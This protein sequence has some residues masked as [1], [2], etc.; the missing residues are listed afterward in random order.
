M[1][2]KTTCQCGF[3][4]S[5]KDELAGKKVKCPRCAHALQIPAANAV[6]AAGA[7]SSGQRSGARAL[8][9]ALLDLL[10]EEGVQGIPQGPICHSC[11]SVMSASSVICVNC[12]F[13][14]ATGEHLETQIDY[15]DDHDLDLEGKSHAES[16]LARAEKDIDESPITSEGQDFGDG[17]DSYII[18]FA[19]IA[20]AGI[21]IM[22]GL[23]VVLV[24][25]YATSAINPAMIGVIVGMIMLFVCYISIIVLAFMDEVVKGV[26]SLLFWPYAVYY[27]IVKGS[28][29]RLLAIISI[30]VFPIV[31]FGQI[32]LMSSGE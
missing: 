7:A 29:L 28:W 1:P 26:L 32:Y 25:E 22:S 14:T 4:F 13:N 19:A 12:G 23:A 18:A 30:I 31:I 16:L 10:D 11:G 8:N 21:L 9:K 6:V 2:I 3:S 5:A 20:I 17:A 24:M 15:G 27:G